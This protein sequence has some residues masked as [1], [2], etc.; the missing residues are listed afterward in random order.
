MAMNDDLFAKIDAA[1]RQAAARAR[2]PPPAQREAVRRKAQDL[3]RRCRLAMD[4]ARAALTR[5]RRG[6]RA[7]QGAL[8]GVSQ[9]AAEHRR[10]AESFRTESRRLREGERSRREAAKKLARLFARSLSENVDLRA[11]LSRTMSS[12]SRD[13]ERAESEQELAETRET[14]VNLMLQLSRE[15]RR[16]EASLLSVRRRLKGLNPSA[17]RA[18]KRLEELQLELE[19]SQETA[20][21]LLVELTR[22]GRDVDAARK[23]GGRAERRV[24]GEA[25]NRGYAVAPAIALAAARFEEGLRG[26][27]ESPAMD[28]GA[29]SAVARQGLALTRTLHLAAELS[30]GAG[31]A[32]EP[33]DLL[34]ARL[35]RCLDRWEGEA[36]RRRLT[37]VRRFDGDLPQA[38]VPLGGFEAVLDELFGGAIE[39]APQ[40][41]VIVARAAAAAGGGLSIEVQAGASASKPERAQGAL[42]SLAFSLARELVERWGGRLDVTVS[43]AGRGRRA[44]LFLAAPVKRI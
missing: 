26:V 9:E 23:R 16:W 11:E 5:A 30:E 1:L 31:A 32:A 14:V 24:A 34:R 6:R 20:A 12:P 13:L 40:G 43:A 42:E 8:Q 25:E 17:K 7:A 19:E 18:A 41:S 29:V 35:E 28:P 2:Q 39:R 10:Q 4:R 21:K 22:R 38:V 36:D 33:G 37:I 44:T 27:I 15:R 3:E